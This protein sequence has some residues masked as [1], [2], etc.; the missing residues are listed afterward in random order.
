VWRGRNEFTALSAQVPAVT[1]ATKNWP[2]YID[3]MAVL[4]ELPLSPERRIEV[5]RHMMHI[6]TLARRFVDFPL[7]AELEPAPVFRP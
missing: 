6:E 3:A 1:D 2:A 5:I 4:H 7:E